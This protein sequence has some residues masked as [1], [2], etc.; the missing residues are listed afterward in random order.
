[1][2]DALAPSLK[3]S[4]LFGAGVSDTAGRCGYVLDPDDP[5][6]WGGQQGAECRVDVELLNDDGVWTC[7]H[8]AAD[9]DVLCPFHRPVEETETREVL[10]ALAAAL[11]AAGDGDGDD[12]P[13]AEFLGAEFG[14]VRIDPGSVIEAPVRFDHATVRGGFVAEDVDFDHEVSMKGATFGSGRGRD[15]EPAVTEADGWPPLETTIGADHHGSFPPPESPSERHVSFCRSTFDGGAVFDGVDFEGVRHVSFAHADFGGDGDVSFAATSFENRGHVAFN[16]ADFENHRTVSFRGA[17]FRDGDVSFSVTD[18][19]NTGDVSFESTAFRGCQRV[20]FH[21]SDFC[22][23][24]GVSIH[25]SLADVHALDFD[26]STFTEDVS[27]DITV[28]DGGT[29]SFAGV[30]FSAATPDIRSVPGIN[31]ESATL[32]GVDLSG[33]DLSGANLERATLSNADLFGADLSGARIYGARIGDAAINTETTFDR[34]G[35]HRCVY[36]PDS[37]YEYDPGDDDAVG[38]LRKAMG[39]YH[40]L[41]Q[42]TRANTLPDE[43]AGFFTRRQDM[44]RA[45][46]RRDGSFPRFDY[47]F[48]EA[49]NALFRHGESFSR[50]VAW[51]LGTIA[52]FALL[53]PLGGW[54][55]SES[56]GTIIY[57]R[58]ADS[59]ILL[60]KSVHHSA[61]LFLTGS[62]TLDVSGFA[63]E[64]L[65]TIEALLAPI[66]LA[67]LVFVLGRRAAR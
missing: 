37:A 18:F 14:R 36:D 39:A 9:G 21:D 10:D 54:L 35:A 62:G 31:L 6:T 65:T 27:I 4:P 58:I 47:W 33:V 60:W 67:L 22:N 5:E 53:Y 55:R 42:L 24:A 49:Q 61:L 44:R 2:A 48:A 56:T 7:P 29:V 52:V 59:P 25:V 51:S 43:Q 32:T 19:E 13:P 41:E 40:V 34:H 23:A 12:L 1:M 45:Q 38:Q 8:G 26:G 17:V 46:L 16:K 63:G 3:T 66:L 20:T 11:D 64:V 57:G 50:V 28:E 30:D 15:G